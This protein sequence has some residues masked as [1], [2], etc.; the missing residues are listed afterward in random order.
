VKSVR[1]DG[2]TRRRRSC[3]IAVGAVLGSVGLVAGRSHVRWLVG[4][5]NVLEFSLRRVVDQ[6]R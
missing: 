5:L 2:S 4:G 1:V 3:T 6:D